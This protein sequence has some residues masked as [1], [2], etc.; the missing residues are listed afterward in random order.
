M[1]EDDRKAREA[2]EKDARE[3]ADD[4]DLILLKTARLRNTKW[5]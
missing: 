3:K 5:L 1:H 4:R 2:K